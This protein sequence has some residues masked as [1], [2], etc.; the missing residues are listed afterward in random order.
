MSHPYSLTRPSVCVGIAIDRKICHENSLDIEWK[1]IYVGSAE[2]TDKDQELD[3]CM[4][5]PVPVGVNS[6]AFEV[7]TVSSLPQITPT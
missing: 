7:S 3:T 1:L 5:G 2:S 6:F 4:V